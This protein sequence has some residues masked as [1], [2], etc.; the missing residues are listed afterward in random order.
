MSKPNRILFL[1]WASALGLAA[2]VLADG[3]P[4]TGAWDFMRKQLYGERDIGIPGDAFMKIEV[5][6]STPDPAATSVNI[7]LGPEAQGRIKSLRLIIDNNPAPMVATIDFPA[8]SPIN[9]IETR[10]RVDRFTSVRAVAETTDGGLEMRSQ[11]VNAAGGCSAPSSAAAGGTLGEMRFRPSAD[12]KALQVSIRHPNHSGFQIDP[13]S[14]DPVPPH[15]ITHVRLKA[16][17]SVLLEADL[18]ISISENPL[19]RISSSQPLAGPLTVEA[20]DSRQA[21]FSA[22]W[23]GP[24]GDVATGAGSP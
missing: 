14:G 12:D 15:Y 4:P 21:R 23:K 18:G 1:L 22:V 19:L 10:V 8:G 5:P 24:G 11:W 2:P 7:R 3:P 20:V 13:V 16:G 17:K 6:E 9:G